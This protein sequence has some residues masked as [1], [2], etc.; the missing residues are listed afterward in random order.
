MILRA[1]CNGAVCCGSQMPTNAPS[2]ILRIVRERQ[3]NVKESSGPRRPYPTTRGKI[4]RALATCGPYVGQAPAFPDVNTEE[5]SIGRCAATSEKGLDDR[6]DE[7]HRTRHVLAE[8]VEAHVHLA[9]RDDGVPVR[10]VKQEV[11]SHTIRRQCDPNPP[12]VVQRNGTIR[13]T[14]GQSG[15]EYSETQIECVSHEEHD[16][17]QRQGFAGDGPHWHC[18]WGEHFSKL[19]SPARE[20]PCWGA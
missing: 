4:V 19:D 3:G 18:S 1:F 11:P 13:I 17:L 10:P 7:P 12:W 8:G 6:N 15:G 14:F 5:R 9:C 16:D 20:A 2:L